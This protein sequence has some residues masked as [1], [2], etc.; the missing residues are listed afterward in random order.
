MLPP[1]SAEAPSPEPTE[2]VSHE[3]LEGKRIL[4]LDDEWL[5]A[6]QHAEVFSSVG[7]EIVG[8]FLSLSDA[9]EQEAEAIDLAV[10]DFALEN[11][12]NVLPLAE[13]LRDAEVPIVFVTG[14]GSNTDLP[15]KFDDDLIVPKPASANALL[16]SAARLVA[17]S[18][19]RD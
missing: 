7:A 3:C 11:D 17:Q 16:G 18:Q 6:E 9:L 4:V 19:A 1:S 15:P 14:Y 13:K 2:Y 5:I 10:L 12:E 8:P